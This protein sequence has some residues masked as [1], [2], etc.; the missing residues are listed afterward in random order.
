M[1]YLG[2]TK[3]GKLYLGSTEIAKAYLGNTLVFQK[4]GGGILPAGYKQL[5]YVENPLYTQT[6]LATGVVASNTTGFEIDALTYDAISNTTYGCLFGGRAGSNSSDFQLSTYIASGSTFAGTL[7][8]G[9]ASQNYNAHI[10]VNTRFTAKLSGNT[11]TVGGVDYTTAANIP[12]GKEIYLFALNDNGT[13]AQFSHIRVYRFKLFDGVT[14]LAD[15][16]PCLRKSDNAVGFYDLVSEAFVGPTSGVL[17]G[18]DMSATSY[19]SQVEYLQFNQ[20]AINTGLG[21]TG[22]NMKVEIQ[23]QVLGDYSTTQIIVGCGAGRGQ[24][25]GNVYV[26]GEGKYGVGTSS[27]NYL[28]TASSL[29]KTLTLSY[30]S[31]TRLTDGSSTASV[32]RVAPTSPIQIGRSGGGNYWANMKVWYAKIYAGST[33]LRDFIPVKKGGIGYFYDNVTGLLFGNVGASGFIIGE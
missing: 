3:I 13:A 8:R 7:R 33:L 1:S 27:N 9:T 16:I 31:S 4:G 20:S 14:A 23:C 32:T 18:V 15:Y 28:S 6:Y 29:K 24:W 11:F 17:Y 5:T 25:A 22:T 26:G 21:M 30:T 12:S 10:P 2:T 19:D